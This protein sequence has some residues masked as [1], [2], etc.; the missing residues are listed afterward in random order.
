M[1]AIRLFLICATFGLLGG[2]VPYSASANTLLGNWVLNQELSRELQ[3]AN[4]NQKKN[5][6]GG[7]SGSP[8]VVLGGIPI[9]IPGSGSTQ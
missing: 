7:L 4:T 1:P 5:P 6:F 8:S 2:L 3:P 9:P